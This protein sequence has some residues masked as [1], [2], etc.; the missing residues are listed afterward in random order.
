MIIAVTGVIGSGKSYVAAELAKALA[1]D[2]CDTDEVCRDLLRCGEQG[3]QGVVDKW[4]GLF[5]DESGSIDTVKLRQAIFDEPKIRKSL[6]K[7]LHPLVRI[8][9]EELQKKSIRSGRDLIVEVPLLF[10]VGWQGDFDVV[11]TVSAPRD[12]CLE[13]VVKRDGV[14]VEQALKS[15]EAQMDVEEKARR[16]DYVVDNGQ[17]Q[18]DTLENV[19]ELATVLRKV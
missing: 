19:W 10:E 4:A 16:A 1:A 7:I 12:I 3:W 9:V 11:V 2:R 17:K 15:L 6:E 18:E 8:H 14:S 13:R 5:L